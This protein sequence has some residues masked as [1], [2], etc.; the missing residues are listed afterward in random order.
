MW[1]SSFA[2]AHTISVFDSNGNPLVAAT[3]GRGG[4]WDALAST[5]PVSFKRR[6]LGS[7]GSIGAFLKRLQMRNGGILSG[8]SS[9]DPNVAVRIDS[10]DPIDAVPRD[11][12]VAIHPGN[13][14]TLSQ[15]MQSVPTAR[16]VGTLFKLRPHD[17]PPDDEGRRDAPCSGLAVKLGG[18]NDA[19][20]VRRQEVIRAAEAIPQTDAAR[21]HSAAGRGSSERGAGNEGRRHAGLPSRW[22]P[23]FAVAWASGPAIHDPQRPPPTPRL[24]LGA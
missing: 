2:G 5:T 4:V 11:N 6:L 22:P 23:S 1:T 3:N 16:G 24:A 10:L 7:P 18:G 12:S 17:N 20:A 13:M 9:D 15:P 19:G 8:P 21:P 14:A